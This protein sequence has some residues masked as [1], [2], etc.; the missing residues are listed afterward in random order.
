MV[1]PIQAHTVGSD[2]RTGDAGS[3]QRSTLI[4]HGRH[5]SSSAWWPS[6]EVHHPEQPS[7]HYH[8]IPSWLIEIILHPESTGRSHLLHRHEELK[9][10]S[11]L[12]YAMRSS[13]RRCG[14]SNECGLRLRQGEYDLQPRVLPPEG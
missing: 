3:E 4:G 8:N 10:R 2:G 7:S 5:M 11:V 13:I 14:Q 9:E 6:V 1:Y 12:V